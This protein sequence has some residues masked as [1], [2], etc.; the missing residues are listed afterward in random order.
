MIYMYYTIHFS[1]NIYIKLYII[2][3]ITKNTPMTLSD[4]LHISQLLIFLMKCK[5]NSSAIECL[6]RVLIIIGD[7]IFS[8]DINRA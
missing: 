3:Y 8:D 4:E 1:Y 6:S 7:Y 5:F 2:I